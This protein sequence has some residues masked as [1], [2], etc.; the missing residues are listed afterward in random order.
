MEH[1]Q[2]FD[3]SGLFVTE[4]F[5]LG[6]GP[7]LAT[8]VGLAVGPSL[9]LRAA[10]RRG[11]GWLAWDRRCRHGRTPQK[12]EDRRGMG[13]HAPRPCAGEVTGINQ[14]SRLQTGTTRLGEGVPGSGSPVMGPKTL[15]GSE[16]STGKAR[17]SLRHQSKR[18]AE[19]HTAGTQDSS[20]P[21]PERW[22]SR[23]A[24]IW[25]SSRPQPAGRGRQ[26]AEDRNTEADWGMLPAL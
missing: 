1:R 8:V 21:V 15:P 25:A 19:T 13:G 7:R 24:R 22:R 12:R 17:R 26:R 16:S 2:R 6:L 3:V 23:A 14:Q 9:S 18:R 20:T 10:G 5:A 11:G 4:G